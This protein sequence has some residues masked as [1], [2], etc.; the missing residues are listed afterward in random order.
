[1]YFEDKYHQT[2]PLREDQCTLQELLDSYNSRNDSIQYD[3][4]KCNCRTQAT[5]RNCVLQYP[6][7]LCIAISR[8]SLTTD[9]RLV[10]TAVDYPIDTFTPTKYKRFQQTDR[11][12]NNTNKNTDKYYLIAVINCD[13]NTSEM[14]H[15]TVICKQHI[16]GLWYNYDDSR[17]TRSNFSKTTKK[18]CMPKVPFQ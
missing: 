17:V 16:S 7:V 8:G 11:E 10:N 12:V 5:A 3:C 6:Q 15:F 14:G 13:A 2:K 9:N 4:L 1:M 18:N